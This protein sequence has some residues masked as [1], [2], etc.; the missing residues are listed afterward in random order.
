MKLTVLRLP[1]EVQFQVET[2]ILGEANRQI[3]EKLD[4]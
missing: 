1:L 4:G 2:N 3:T